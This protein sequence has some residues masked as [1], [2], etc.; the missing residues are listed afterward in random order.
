[1]ASPDGAGVGDGRTGRGL[2]SK[3]TCFDELLNQNSLNSKY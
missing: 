1:M 2:V 3:I